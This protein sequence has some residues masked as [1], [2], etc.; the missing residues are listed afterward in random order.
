MKRKEQQ[1]DTLHRYPERRERERERERQTDR[2]TDRQ[3][4]RER[5]RETERDRERGCREIILLTS[6]ENLKQSHDRLNHRE[7][8]IE[9][10]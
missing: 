4:Q 7:I 9:K 2:Q 10:S 8:N 1:I 6:K 3:R 5:Q